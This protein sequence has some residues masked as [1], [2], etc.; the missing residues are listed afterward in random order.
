MVR[1]VL[2]IIRE[3]AENTGLGEQFTKAMERVD[4]CES[5]QPAELYILLT[6]ELFQSLMPPIPY[7][8][9]IPR[10]RLRLGLRASLQL[11]SP[12]SAPTH[13]S[14]HLPL[15]LRPSSRP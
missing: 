15:K 10:N 12:S 14:T 8:P 6:Q 9:R 1:R 13:H 7:H 2:G 5:Q 11:V 4:K 3:E